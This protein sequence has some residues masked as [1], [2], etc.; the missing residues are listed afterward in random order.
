MAPAT[1]FAGVRLGQ[2]LFA[3]ALAD[4]ARKSKSKCRVRRLR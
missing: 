1:I 3:P 2:Q 4:R